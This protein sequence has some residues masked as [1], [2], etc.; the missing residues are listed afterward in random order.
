MISLRT[1]DAL[2][3][4]KARGK[5]LG[6]LREHGRESYSRPQSSRRGR[7]IKRADRAGWGVVTLRSF[8]MRAN[9]RADYPSMLGE[10]R[11]HRAHYPRA[12]QHTI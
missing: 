7:S 11:R 1:K 10:D 5:K 12:R 6:G 8:G 2:A 9:S 4:A 3:A